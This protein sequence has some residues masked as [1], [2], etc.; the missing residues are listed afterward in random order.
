MTIFE[1]TTKDIQVLVEPRYEAERSRPDRSL[2]V[3]SYHVVIKNNGEVPIQVYKR[4]WVITDAFSNIECI[5]GEG[6][7]GEQPVIAPGGS[8]SYTSHC[9][10]KT[11]FGSM[12]GHYSAITDAGKNLKIDIPEFILAYPFAVQ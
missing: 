5:E 1:K 4:S 2:F 12:K 11:N 9:P 3:F 8:F 6:V 10:L 7:V